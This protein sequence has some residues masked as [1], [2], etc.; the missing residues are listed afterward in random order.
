MIATNT[1]IGRPNVIKRSKAEIEQQLS[2]Y[3][4]LL[5]EVVQDAWA[6]WMNSPERQ[7]WHFNRGRANYIF[8]H[9]AAS[10]WEMF[11]DDPRIK[12]VRK[13][14]TLWFLVDNNLV[15]RFKKADTSF[16]SRN[17][18]T[19]QAIAFH[20]EQAPLFEELDH[21]EVVYL[22]NKIGTA[23]R[24]ICVVARADKSVLWTI[25]LLRGEVDNVVTLAPS[26]VIDPRVPSV[27]A[28]PK[29]FVVK[30]AAGNDVS[31]KNDSSEST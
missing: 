21:V 11:G 29:L 27:A 30:G 14:E 12:V 4:D 13:D 25:S 10:A 23:I 26:P 22:V 9:V 15:F 5:C 20:D 8:E 6:R 1:S 24:D 28:T 19:Q 7:R 16:L 18:P 2:P 31:K 3:F 17:V